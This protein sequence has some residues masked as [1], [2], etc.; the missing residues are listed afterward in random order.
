MPMPTGL[1]LPPVPGLVPGGIQ[2]F[3]EI[4]KHRMGA[5][6][7]VDQA[8]LP[9]AGDSCGQDVFHNAANALSS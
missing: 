6:P 3:I 4:V 1:L 9:Y 7:L 2:G 5:S 8:V